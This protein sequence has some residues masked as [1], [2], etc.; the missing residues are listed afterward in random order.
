MWI[1]SVVG[2]HVDPE[3]P[4]LETIDVG[5][6]VD[7]LRVRP[8]RLAYRRRGV[9]LLVLIAV[10]GGGSLAAISSRHHRS[11]SPDKAAARTSVVPGPAREPTSPVHSNEPLLGRYYPLLDRTDTTTIVLP[12]GL[13]VTLS[14]GLSKAIGGLGAHFFATV[15]PKY[16]ADCCAL[17]FG[18]DHAAPSDLFATLGPSAI[19]TPVLV[20]SARAVQPNLRQVAGRFGI[21]STGDW[22]LIASFENG[23]HTAAADA[24]VLK[25]LDSWHLRSTQNGAVLR[26]PATSIIDNIEANFGSTPDLTD[27]EIDL[28]ASRCAGAD[29]KRTI[30]TSYSPSRRKGFWCE[31]GLRVNVEGPQSYVQSVIADLKVK[32]GPNG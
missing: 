4:N 18:I 3:T 24:I 5:G 7:R 6:N 27:K 32:V 31:R 19:S 2:R 8:S 16:A 10:V 12:T 20:S 13:T 26:V 17:S 30:V 9:A 21:L 28:N 1:L 14:G 15:T 22:T 25:L 11:D 29:T 23:D